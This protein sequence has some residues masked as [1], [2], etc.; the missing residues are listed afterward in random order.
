MAVA[1]ASADVTQAPAKE[2]K[3]PLKWDRKPDRRIEREWVVRTEANGDKLVVDLSCSHWPDRK[4]YVAILGNARIGADGVASSF[5]MSSEIIVRERV[6]RYSKPKFEAFADAALG[7]LRE[8]VAGG[9]YGD[10][11]RGEHA[12]TR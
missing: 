1:E 9:E 11:L 6:D 3:F 7:Q 12:P 5:P 10:F 8:A 2:R 4:M